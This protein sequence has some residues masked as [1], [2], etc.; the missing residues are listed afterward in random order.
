MGIYWKN[1]VFLCHILSSIYHFVIGSLM[2]FW[3][4]WKLEIKICFS[5]WFWPFAEWQE[6]QNETK[7]D[8][9]SQNN[10]V[11]YKL[12]MICKWS[13]WSSSSF[14]LIDAAVERQLEEPQI[15]RS[16]HLAQSHAPYQTPPQV[17]LHTTHHITVPYQTQHTTAHITTRTTGTRQPCTPHHCTTPRH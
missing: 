13:S 3:S 6:C 12:E 5:H 2:G 15:R 4:V 7:V 8:D 17:S 11:N 9:K 10:Q 1:F 14:G 16:A